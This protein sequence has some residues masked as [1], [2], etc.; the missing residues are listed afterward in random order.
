[1][2]YLT[3]DNPDPGRRTLQIL[4]PA[5][6]GFDQAGDRFAWLN[7]YCALRCSVEGDDVEVS[8]DVLIGD[9]L[10]ENPGLVARLADALDPAAVLVGMDLTG[11]VSRLGRLPID[12]PDQAPSLALLAKLRSMLERNKPIDLS[13]PDGSCLDSLNY[14]RLA[15]ELT[16]QAS[17]CLL[18]ASHLALPGRLQWKIHEAWHSWRRLLVPVLPEREVANSVFA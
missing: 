2:E 13:E 6:R 12:A 9:H 17:A 18:A 11:I 5:C 15:R 10:A 7:G 4:V 14:H 8:G 3:N 1:M 16:D